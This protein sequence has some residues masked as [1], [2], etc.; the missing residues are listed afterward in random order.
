MSSIVTTHPEITK[1]WHPSKNTIDIY[2]LA[3]GSG[4][5]VWWLCPNKCPRGCLHEWESRVADR[6]KNNQGCPYCV[7]KRCC[8]HTSIIAT[9]PDIAKQWHPTKNVDISVEKVT[10]GSQRK[11]WWLCSNKCS[12]GCLHEWEAMVKDRCFGY[13][14]PY[15]SSFTTRCCIHTS[16]VTTHTEIV[17]EWHPSK[18]VDINPEN[19]TSGSH[20]KVWWLCPN[21]CPQGCLHEWET[22]VKDKCKI[23]DP[24]KCPYCNPYTTSCCIHTSIVTTHPEIASQIHLTKNVDINPENITFGS[25]RKLWWICSFGHEWEAYVNLR[26]KGTNC[27]VCKYRTSEKL[28]NYIKSIFPD[29]ISE[30]RVDWCKNPFTDR[31]L[32][33]DIYIPS[34]NMIIELDGP[35]HFRQVSNWCNPEFTQLKDVYKM[36]LAYTQKIN[37]IRILQ[38]D[39]YKNSLEWLDIN[40]KPELIKRNENALFIS[41]IDVYDKLINLYTIYDEK[42]C[43]EKLKIFHNPIEDTTDE[44]I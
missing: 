39:V 29:A 4:K 20:K 19:L 13:G 44:E 16:I 33:F 26:H 23:K 22:T 32:P 40:L 31:C 9:H 34:L 6:C 35:Q 8:R 27:P 3:S 15:C 5:K 17:K 43:L 37:V 41:S 38:E 10:T 30:Y 24:I 7:N 42:Q 36:R 18:N 1:Q 14:C 21:K 2:E 12:K 25:N 11:V 28:F